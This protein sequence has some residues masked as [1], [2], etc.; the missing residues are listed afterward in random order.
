MLVKRLISLPEDANPMRIRQFMAEKTMRSVPP[1][2]FASD[3]TA[4]KTNIMIAVKHNVRKHA[5]I[6]KR[7]R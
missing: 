2:M 1:V 3:S 6:G 5:M 4:S 7:P